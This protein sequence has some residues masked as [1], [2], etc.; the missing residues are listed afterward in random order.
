MLVD[1]AKSG[2][3]SNQIPHAAQDKNPHSIRKIATG[4]QARSGVL[5]FPRPRE[6]LSEVK[7]EVLVPN[8]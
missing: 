2:I 8:T 4:L 5:F 7:D 6:S 3:N 1:G